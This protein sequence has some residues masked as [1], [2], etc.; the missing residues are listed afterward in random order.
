MPTELRVVNEGIAHDDKHWYF[1]NQ[2]FIYKTK[3]WPIEIELAN[4]KA[5]GEE[6]TH[7]SYNHIG[8]I[9]IIGDLI[10]GGIEANEGNGALASW[11]TTDLSMIKYR[12]TEQGDMPWVAIDKTTRRIYSCAWND[13]AQLQMY[14]LDTFEFIGTLPVNTDNNS[15]L[16]PKE[17]QGGAFYNGDLYLCT[18][19]DD[20]IWKINIATGVVS[21]ALSDP[22][23][24][25]YDY[26]MEGIDFWDLRDKGFGVM[27][28]FGN[29]MKVTEKSV[30][31]Y[32][33]PVAF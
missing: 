27:H 11:N 18:N 30:I 12:V 33:P 23:F 17:I 5:I 9:D 22:I 25:K 15:P 1:T 24:D 31:S 8:D 4:Y 28:V 10:I 16:L 29:F 26:E 13:Q 6:L 2:H 7:K 21:F 14:D 32:D 20:A 19:I 3:Q